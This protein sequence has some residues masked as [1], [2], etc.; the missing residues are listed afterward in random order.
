MKTNQ[1]RKKYINFFKEKGHKVFSSDSLVP[2]DPSVLFTSAGM[3]QFKPYFLGQN[4]KVNTAVSC[5]RC[6]R[7]GDIERVGQTPYHHTFFEMLGN[8]S[9]GDYFKKD[10]ISLAWEFL[11][12]SLKIDK[13][14]LWVSVYKKDKE[15]FAIWK[16][17]VGV[18]AEK[19]IKLDQDENFWPA[20]VIEQGPSGPCGPCSEIFFDRGSNIGC[21]K[22]SCN[23]AC[24]CNRFVEIWNLVF[25]QF[26]RQADGSLKPLPQKNID[27][28]MGLE[29][30]ASVLQNKN[31]NFEIDI[32]APAVSKVKEI[33]KLDK[34]FDKNYLINSI[35]DHSRAVMFSIADGVYPSNEERGYVIRK[36][37]RKSLWAANLCGYK[38]SFVYKL[39]PVF[40]KMMQEPYPYLAKKEKVIK[41]VIKAEEEKFILTLE[42]G[43]NKFSEYLQELK[44]KNKK[45][46]PAIK[47]FRLY[48]T[49]GF[50]FELSETMAKENNISVD[51][52]G[53]KK[54]LAKQKERSR[55]GS[56]FSKDIFT[57]NS[58]LFGGDEPTIFVGYQKIKTNARIIHILP[59]DKMK[60]NWHKQ[61]QQLQKGENG[62]II[63]DKT[64]FYPESGGQLSD[65]GR[66]KTNQGVFFVEN[67]YKIGGGDIFVHR[68]KVTEGIIK[69]EDA[70][71]IVDQKRRQ[72]LKRAHTATHLLQAALKNCLGDHVSQQGSLVDVDRLRFDFTHFK[73][74]TKKEI[75]TT[76]D[77]VNTYIFAANKINKEEKSL[78]AAKKEGALAFFKEKYKDKVRMV[79]VSNYSKELCG[80]TH[81]ENTSEVGGF[82]IVSESSVSSGIRRIEAVT[83]NK[84]YQLF[85]RNK[86]EIID[87]AQLL[88]CGPAGVKQTIIKTINSYKDCKS[89]IGKI[90]K[91]KILDISEKLIKDSTEKVEGTDLLVYDFTKKDNFSLEYNNFFDL[92]DLIKKQTKLFF[93]FVIG[94]QNDKIRFLCSCSKQL[95]KKG[96]SCRSFIDQFKDELSIKGGGT[97]SL[98]QGVVSGKDDN[99][100]QKVKKYIMRYLKNEGS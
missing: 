40:I 72:A 80:G 82:A 93:I 65:C 77:L 100:D 25:T 88:K 35:V 86:K 84:F 28:G 83:G 99:L 18:P 4:K 34:N 91:E 61:K 36:L 10:A 27:T 43:K 94:R 67:V 30:M 24:D 58:S 64:S 63:L 49:Y 97:D 9:F 54:L 8:F 1:L 98:A 48:D 37:L 90:A 74:L 12:Q 33:L 96:V 2:D 39:L 81:L 70:E 20:N 95:N 17:K 79:S 26:D 44:N 5:Q 68:G 51:K 89:K 31:S 21:K 92:L 23:P 22:K 60:V 50:P 41:K 52:Q 76:E 46:L 29:R 66:I 45:V 42:E 16:D 15:A 87:L 32:L 73:A 57:K 56:K 59:L 3:N 85:K 53:A 71:L 7:T 47:L 62:I 38:K 19:I 13:K 14:N 6:L 55:A 11:T 78:E 69:K 75:E